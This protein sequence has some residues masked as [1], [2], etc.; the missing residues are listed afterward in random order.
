[1]ILLLQR[2][3]I[4]NALQHTSPFKTLNS[5]KQRLKHSATHVAVQNS[6]EREHNHNCL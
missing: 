4:A 3:C 2:Y 6:R 1:M 5:K